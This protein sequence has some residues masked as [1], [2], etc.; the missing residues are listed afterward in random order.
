MEFK[1]NDKLFNTIRNDSVIRTDGFDVYSLSEIEKY[2]KHLRTLFSEFHNELIENYRKSVEEE[3][4]TKYLKQ[5]TLDL[6]EWNKV[7]VYAEQKIKYLREDNDIA[8]DS[9][10]KDIL[11]F[12]KEKVRYCSK[13][14]NKIT[15]QVDLLK[16]NIADNKKDIKYMSRGQEFIKPLSKGI[17]GFIWLLTPAAKS[18]FLTSL[19]ENG[20]IPRSTSIE[21]LNKAFSKTTDN[22]INANLGIKWLLET[23]RSKEIHKGALLYFIMQLEDN[24]VIAI[25]NPRSRN[26]KIRYC[27]CDKN[28]GKIEN[29]NNAVL[30]VKGQNKET[31]DRIIRLL[32]AE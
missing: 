16:Q 2:R 5:L 11:K 4:E 17:N 30:P 23:E 18:Y 25:E 22:K 31:I 29:L 12:L 19:T 8:N 27:F 28:V 26:R 13:A 21:T 24:H 14:I 10:E 1:A 20:L 6:S 7:Y 9:N 15:T 32:L 3:K